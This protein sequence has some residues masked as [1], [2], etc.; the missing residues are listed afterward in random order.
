MKGA[1]P[2]DGAASG[3]CFSPRQNLL[4]A[5]RANAIGCDCRESDPPVCATDATGRGVGL[6]CGPDR[7][8]LAVEDGPCGPSVR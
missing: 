7:H 1:D 3:T 4:S 6:V 5:Y 8:W 2:L